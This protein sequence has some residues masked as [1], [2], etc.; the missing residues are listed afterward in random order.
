MPKKV[1]VISLKESLRSSEIDFLQ[2][3]TPLLQIA[4]SL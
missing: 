4:E 2:F 1:V 3:G